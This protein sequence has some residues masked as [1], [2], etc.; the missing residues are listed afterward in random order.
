MFSIIVCISNASI[1]FVLFVFPLKVHLLEFLVGHHYCKSANKHCSV[2]SYNCSSNHTSV[3][4]SCLYALA[5]KTKKFTNVCQKERKVH[6][7]NYRNWTDMPH[8]DRLIV[9]KW[10]PFFFGSESGSDNLLHSR[11]VFLI[12]FFSRGMNSNACHYQEMEDK[13]DMIDS[14]TLEI[15]LSVSILSL[16]MPIGLSMW[17]QIMVC[18]AFLLALGKV[19]FLSKGPHLPYKL[20]NL[21]KIL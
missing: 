21:W 15:L 3:H 9:K 10:Q 11:C 20:C 5:K 4:P 19:H 16:L 12:L 8:Y 7:Q 18:H 2:P 13:F 1:A 17:I 14:F 6:M